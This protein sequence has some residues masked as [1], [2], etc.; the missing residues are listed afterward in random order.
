MASGSRIILDKGASATVGF[1]V[2]I[3]KN[4]GVI[5]TEALTTAAGASQAITLTNTLVGASSVLLCQLQGGTN[6]TKNITIS[7]VPG[8]GSAVITIYNND[9]AAA[10]NGT[11]IIGF[12]VF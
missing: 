2:T 12:T 9:P 7:A 8:I 11:V 5:T 3:S 6:T 1:A 10:L 4:A